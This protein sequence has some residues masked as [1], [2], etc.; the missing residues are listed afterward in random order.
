MPLYSL[1]SNAQHQLS[2]PHTNDVHS[3]TLT[4]LTFPPDVYPIKIVAGSNHT[5]LL[6]NTWELY[7]TGANHWGQC[8]VKGNDV[9]PS[10]ERVGGGRRWRDCAAT[11]EGSIL[12]DEGGLIWSCGRIKNHQGLSG[13]RF[14][15]LVGRDMARENHGR[16]VQVS[17]GVQH[18]IIFDDN[19]A[20]GFGDGRKGQFGSPTTLTTGVRLPTSDIHQVSCG[21][22]FTCILSSTGQISLYT[23]STKHNIQTIPPLPEALYFLTS[24]WSTISILDPIGRIHS[25]GRNDRSQSP[26][27]GLPLIARLAGGSE[28][29]IA[30]SQTDRVYAWGWNEHGNCGLATLEDVSSVHELKVPEDEVPVYIAGGCGTSWIWTKGK[31]G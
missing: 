19:E 31:K 10:F 15:D 25:W 6:T 5:L 7:A 22:D 26:P 3:P 2:L 20:I 8:F 29:F 4:T 16:D 28:H 17:A 30:L 21:K 24:S 18:F 23:I 9:L 13:K 27:E 1:G 14:D 11:W 12:V